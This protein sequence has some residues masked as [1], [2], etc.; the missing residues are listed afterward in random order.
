MALISGDI[1]PIT[2]KPKLI[3]RSRLSFSEIR[4][5]CPLHKYFS[6]YRWDPVTESNVPGG[7]IRI[8][9]RCNHATNYFDEDGLE[10]R[11]MSSMDRL[12][13]CSFGRSDGISLTRSCESDIHSLHQRPAT[14]FPRAL[15]H[16]NS[17]QA[18][19]YS[20]STYSDAENT[21]SARTRTE[22]TSFSGT[23]RRE[24]VTPFVNPRSVSLDHH[25]HQLADD[26][27]NKEDEEKEQE[28]NTLQ[29]REDNTET[30]ES[31]KLS[32]DE[33]VDRNPPPSPPQREKEH[34]MVWFGVIL[35]TTL[36]IIGTV[37]TI[38]LRVIARRKPQKGQ[39]GRMIVARTAC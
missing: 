15:Y 5:H 32:V 2:E 10:C 13:L 21:D 18:I 33:N 7:H 6:L 20:S 8:A 11:S 39:S 4:R 24:I 28:D 38:T 34:R 26:E 12:S 22:R 31:N 29:Q 37:A 1:H 9:F 27:L 14:A 16:S 19:R 23:F 36:G 30:V 25:P 35:G 17:Q 3:A